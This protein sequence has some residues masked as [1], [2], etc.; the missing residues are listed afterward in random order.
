[1][2]VNVNSESQH[3]FWL[4]G[5]NAKLINI[6]VIKT[7][8]PGLMCD[9]IDTY[10]KR[11]ACYSKSDS[12]A[13]V[14]L[15]VQIKIV[16]ASADGDAFTVHNFTSKNFTRLC[17]KDHVIPKTVKAEDFTKNRRVKAQLT[18]TIVSI[19]DYGNEYGGWTAMG[20]VRRGEICDEAQLHD[21][22][23]RKA[24]LVEATNLTHHVT[25][26]MPTACKICEVIK[27][28]AKSLRH[29]TDST[30]ETTATNACNS[31]VHRNEE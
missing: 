8:C 30:K 4:M 19:L 2:P 29:S 22:N 28:D 25:V 15:C 9:A 7:G 10:H 17:M 23:V 21:P 31:G 27:F 5:T 13:H 24:E 11:C 12:Q 3:G 18:K 1:M 26:L 20:W 14:V 16:P 6:H